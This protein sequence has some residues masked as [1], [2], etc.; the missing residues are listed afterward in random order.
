MTR[1]LLAE[2]G[3]LRSRRLTWIAVALVALVIA[4]LQ[5]AVWQSVKPLTPAELAQGQA[6]YQ[7]ARQDYEQN[8]EQYAEQE[9]QCVDAGNTAEQCHYEPKPEDY[10]SRSVIPFPE[11]AKITLTSSVFLTTLTLLLLGASFIGAEYTSGALANW[12]S[13]IPERGKVFATKLLALT[14]VAA[15]FTAL[16]SAVTIVAAVLVSRAVGGSVSEVGNLFQIG[17]RGVL[18]GV[19]GTVLGFCLAMVTRHTIAAAG[20]VLGYLLVSSVVT[21][22][23]QSIESLQG[24]V[25]WLP[26][27]NLQA[28]LNHG[29]SYQVY[30]RVITDSGGDVSY[31]E[32]S[33]SFAHGLGYWAVVVAV[34]V[35]ATFAVFRRRDVN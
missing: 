6:Q 33:I 23:V 30:G 29:Y 35:A 19:I 10:A 25:P 7:Q 24:L 31:V 3:R 34:A 16:T 22:L 12:L 2:L 14:L 21:A 28:I 1:L 8:R 5:I 18:I 27:S 9:K 13:F 17:G 26:E 11:I 15:V 32:R 4:L 20:V